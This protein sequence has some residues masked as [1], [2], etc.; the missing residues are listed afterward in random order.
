MDRRYAYIYSLPLMARYSQSS[1]TK[2]IDIAI[3]RREKSHN[4]LILLKSVIT[5]FQYQISG[6]IPQIELIAIIV[7][8]CVAWI[9]TATPV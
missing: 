1:M 7:P 4:I 5:V 6:K 3:G 8:Y 9:P 2:L